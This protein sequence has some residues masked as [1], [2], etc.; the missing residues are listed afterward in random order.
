MKIEKN[1]IVFGMIIGIVI[2][3]II[4]YSMMVFQDEE[5]TELDSNKI[6]IPELQD[7]QEEYSSKLD[8]INDLKEIQKRNAPSIYDERLLDSS[9][10][11]DPD[12]LDKEK[13]R[14]VDS[15]YNQG[16]INYTESRY[17]RT[18]KTSL[19]PFK[20][21]T[22]DSIKNFQEN[23]TKRIKESHQSF[24]IS[25]PK[26]ENQNTNKET[27]EFIPVVVSGEQ[28]VK[29]HSRLRLRLT[30]TATINNRLIPK[31]TYLY[32]FVSFK[33][34][35]VMI[36]IT[37]IQN[38]SVSLKAF[39]LQDGNE[40]IYAV[41][42]FKIDVSKAIVGDV[43]DNI[44]IPGIPSVDV[45]KNVFQRSNRNTKVTITNNYKLLLKQKL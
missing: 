39:D 42:N 9:G 31:N 18:P 2:L 37:N 34:N 43:V 4:T 16:R 40:G 11:F 17:R 33:P 36:H 14:I 12:L 29:T 3:F 13:Q 10:V 5:E 25:V 6:P 20:K 15:I 1:K 38:K 23:S 26:D 45:F 44:N 27:D 7:E 22:N 41:N 8:A 30:E 35:R 24:F 32:G 21:S 19:P 28:M